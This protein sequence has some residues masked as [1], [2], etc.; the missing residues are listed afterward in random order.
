MKTLVFPAFLLSLLVFACRKVEPEAAFIGQYF[1]PT[2]SHSSQFKEVFTSPTQSHFEWVY[3]SSFK[4]PDTLRLAKISADSFALEGS[5]AHQVPSEWRRFAFA[6]NTGPTIFEFE[7]SAALAGYFSRSL[8]LKIN[9][10]TGT[11]DFEYLSDYQVPISK[12]AA[13]FEGKK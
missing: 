13:S 11:T 1:G 9:T 7:R 8:L 4:N 2:T 5:A 6:E 3:D 12:T 10:E